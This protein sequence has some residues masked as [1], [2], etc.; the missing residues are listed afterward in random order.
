VQ[1]IPKR[2]VFPISEVFYILKKS[3]TFLEISFL[4]ASR[5]NCSPLSRWTYRGGR[6]ASL[7]G[8]PGHALRGSALRASHH[9]HP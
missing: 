2:P 6:L 3:F 4:V 8:R 1:E 5:K 7:I 9:I